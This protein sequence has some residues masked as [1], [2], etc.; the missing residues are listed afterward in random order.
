MAHKKLLPLGNFNCGILSARL[1]V[2]NEQTD[3]WDTVA[4]CIDTPNSIARTIKTHHLDRNKLW[5]LDSL[6]NRRPLF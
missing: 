2:I 6:G 4:Q 1:Q 5:C 3:K